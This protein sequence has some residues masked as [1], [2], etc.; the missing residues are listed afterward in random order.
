MKRDPGQCSS[1]HSRNAPFDPSQRRSSPGRHHRGMRHPTA[2]RLMFLA[3]H[4]WTSPR[5]QVPQKE[6]QPPP[7]TIF[8]SLLI[9]SCTS[10]PPGNPAPCPRR[11]SCSQTLSPRPESLQ[12]LP[13]RGRTLPDR[14][15]QSLPVT[16]S[17]EGQFSL[18]DLPQWSSFGLYSERLFSRAVWLRAWVEQ[19]RRT[20]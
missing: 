4:G 1:V 13:L 11:S 5:I 6:L 14:I 7:T 3:L 10:G 18:R 12:T 8:S 20:Y 19:R 16:L 2:L 9:A 15:T 17:G